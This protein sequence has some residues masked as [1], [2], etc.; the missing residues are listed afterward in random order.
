MP[1]KGSQFRHLPQKSLKQKSTGG[2]E[3]PETGQLPLYFCLRSFAGSKS[4]D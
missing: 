1:A 4:M 3:S 2:S